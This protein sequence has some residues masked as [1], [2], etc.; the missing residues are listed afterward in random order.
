[1]NDEG[2]DEGDVWRSVAT[3]ESGGSLGVCPVC[4]SCSKVLSS[5]C[6]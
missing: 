5:D 1:V 2:T 4:I 6:F 3:G